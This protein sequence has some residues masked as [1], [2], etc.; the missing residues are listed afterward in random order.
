MAVVAAAQWQWRQRG[1]SGGSLAE[2]AAAAA[3]AEALRCQLGVV[4]AAAAAACLQRQRDGGGNGS[5]ATAWR[6]W[7]WHL[8]VT[9]WWRCG[10]GGSLV[11]K[12][13]W[14]RWKHHGGG[15]GDSSLTAAAGWHWERDICGGDGSATAR[16]RWCFAHAALRWQLCRCSSAGFVLGQGQRDN[17]AD[18]VVVGNSGAH[19]GVHHGCGGADYTEG[20]AED[21]IC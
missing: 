3:K 12:A 9:A 8:V 15:N 2:A 10:D 1:G 6:R 4:V 5:R 20:C 18:G 13:L 16:L 11:D 19:G 17:G 7:R 14:W 21:I